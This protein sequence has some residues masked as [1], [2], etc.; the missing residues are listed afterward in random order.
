MIKYDKINEARLLVD[1][2]LAIDPES[3][4]G[5]RLLIQIMDSK[6]IF[7]NLEIRFD[8]FKGNMAISSLIGLKLIDDYPE[9]A[10]EYLS[11]QS[12]ENL[13]LKSQAL[14]KLT[15]YKEAILSAKKAIKLKPNSIEG[16][17]LCGWCHFELDN[18]QESENYFE[19]ALGC[20]INNPDAL[21]G[22]ALILKSQKKDYSYY[23]RALES[24]NSD[25]SI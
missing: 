10:I 23:N 2:G 4:A 8:I 13:I 9:K 18:Y 25:L 6:E 11:N 17:I 1:K 22:K 21:L 7:S 19:G 3:I 14:K 16:W 24:I 12:H 15:K 20:D 5:N